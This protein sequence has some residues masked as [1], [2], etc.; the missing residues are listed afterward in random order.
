MGSPARGAWA[1]SRLH[2][3]QILPLLAAAISRLPLG[4]V[5]HW[6]MLALGIGANVAL[7]IGSW[8]QALA[9]RPAW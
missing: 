9:A 3:L 2:A 6:A 1:S 7:A 5:A 8:L 4:A